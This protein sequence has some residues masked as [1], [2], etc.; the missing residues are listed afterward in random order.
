MTLL[1]EGC[2]IKEYDTVHRLNAQRH[3]H[4]HAQAEESF[5]AH[6]IQTKGSEGL[7][8]LASMHIMSSR[9]EQ[10]MKVQRDRRIPVGQGRWLR[11]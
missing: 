3:K 7:R 6:D 8:G 4:R 2:V 10:H 5:R 1:V 11:K 9:G